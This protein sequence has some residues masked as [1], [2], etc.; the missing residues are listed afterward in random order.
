MIRWISVPFSKDTRKYLLLAMSSNDWIIG[1]SFGTV[2]NE[3]RVPAYALTSTTA[4]KHQVPANKRSD[5]DDDG[6]ELP[7]K[8][9][10]PF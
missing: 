10:M 7:A 2:R 8:R 1:F 4:T 9:S 6:K 3:I 5:V